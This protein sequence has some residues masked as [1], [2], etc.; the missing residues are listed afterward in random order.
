MKIFALLL[1]NFYFYA[2][3]LHYSLFPVPCSLFTALRPAKRRYP[4]SRSY[5][6]ILPSSL[7]MLLPSAFGFSPR[8]PVSVCGTG[9]NV[10]IA[11]F[12]DSV[13]S[14]A[15]LLCFAPHRASELRAA[16]FPA[17]P[18]LRL[19]RFFRSRLFLPSCVPTVLNIRGAGI[20]TS[21]PS[22]TAPALALGP[23]LP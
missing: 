11:A 19:D 14:E 21:F 12:L 17:A 20:S 9:A 5:G 13:G 6:V 15:S 2:F 7:T 4:F 8:L 3:D 22:A 23:G 10:A 18:P 1:L 16:A